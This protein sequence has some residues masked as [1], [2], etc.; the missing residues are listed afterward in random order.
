MRHEKKVW[1]EYFQR[2]VDGT[3]R[4]ELRLAD[5]DCNSGDE[6]VLKEWDPH[7]KQYTGRELVKSVTYVMRTKDPAHEKFWPKDEIEKHGFQIISFE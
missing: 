7:T 4:Y 5:W 6:L 3:K 2:I 1:P